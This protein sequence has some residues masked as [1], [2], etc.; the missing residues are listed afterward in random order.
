MQVYSGMNQY[1]AGNDH[2]GVFIQAVR[3]STEAS[4]S[5]GVN[6]V[7][8]EAD[9]WEFC[10]TGKRTASDFPTYPERSDFPAKAVFLLTTTRLPSSIYNEGTVTSAA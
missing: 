10:L 3:A 9:S 6:R 1:V 7:N 4:R 8:G 2:A 5:G